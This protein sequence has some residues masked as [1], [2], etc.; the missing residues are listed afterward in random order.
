MASTASAI[1][2]TA[3]VALGF[4]TPVSAEM[5]MTDA[6]YAMLPD[7]CKHKA[8]VS[9]RHQPTPSKHWENELGKGYWAIHHYCWAQVRIARS[10]RYGISREL[11]A[12]ELNTAVNDLNYVIERSQ[13]EMPLL[14]EI[15][16]VKGQVLL[17]V[18]N[19]RA[20]EE[21]LQE[22]I[23]IDP[24]SWRAY[25]YWALHLNQTGRRQE[26]IK[27]VNEGLEQVPESRALKDLAK[28]LKQKTSIEKK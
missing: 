13:P 28:D 14:G 7:Y 4:S 3:F 25:L 22:S 2:L 24:A 19:T 5:Q 17:R 8:A 6:E 12:S 23:R 21:S 1:I 27:L 10:Y 9:A 11:R 18:G 20:A 26:A 16:A 15:L